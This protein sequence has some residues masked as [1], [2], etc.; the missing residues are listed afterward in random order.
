MAQMPVLMV[1]TAAEPESVRVGAEVDG[2]GG[3]GEGEKGESG[4]K[5]E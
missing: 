2:V 3:G 4:E 1:D 5:G